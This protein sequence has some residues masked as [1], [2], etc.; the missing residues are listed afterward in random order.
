[1]VTDLVFRIDRPAHGG[2]CVGRM[3]GRVV[4]CTHCLPGELVRAE[5]LD[6]GPDKRFWRAAAVEVLANA[7]PQRVTSPCPWSGPGRCGGCAW[8]HASPLEQVR[9]KEQ[10]L[11]ETLERIGGLTWPVTVRSLGAGRG[12]RTRVTLHVDQ[13]GRA[14]FHGARSHDLVPVADC[15]QADPRLGLP[16]VLEQDWSGADTVHVSVSDS[17]RAVI[18]DGRL[19]AG[20]T[21]HTDTIEG[22]R[23]IRASGGFWQ[24]HRDGARVL[25]VAVRDLLA[26]VDRVVDLYAG[27]GLFGLTALDA[28]PQAEVTLVEGDREAAGFARRNAARRARVIGVDV[29][30]WRPAPADLVVLDPP[31]AGAGPGVVAAIHAAG[32]AT[33]VYVSCDP[34][35]L[36]R[37]LRLFADRGYLPD[38]IEGFDLF[39]GTAHVE[40]VVR[41]RRG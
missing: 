33:V 1:M 34:A 29:R 26:P 32:P 3:D 6:G 5:L 31:R 10:V 37:D 11:S 23:F 7:H 12:W 25:A 16:E 35:T 17:G 22:R 13:Q 8:L 24:S 14:G 30:R 9:L 2:S 4:F 15:L 27:V 41:L 40:T 19:R 36:A 39:P 38:H 20:P 28:M 18:V 21:E